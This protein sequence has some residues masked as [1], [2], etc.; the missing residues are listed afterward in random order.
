MRNKYSSVCATLMNP[1]EDETA[2]IS[3]LDGD[4]SS[5]QSSWTRDIFLIFLGNN[6]PCKELNVI[7]SE[8]RGL[9]VQTIDSELTIPR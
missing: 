3:I 1:N 4:W 8:K 2:Q 5:R 7:G 9:M 6:K